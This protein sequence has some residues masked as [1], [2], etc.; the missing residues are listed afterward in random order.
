MLPAEQIVV[1]LVEPQDAVNVGGVI[2]VMLNFGLQQL[3]LVRPAPGA[4]DLARLDD[5]AHRSEGIVQRLTVVHTLAQALADVTHVAGTTARPR[6]RPGDT[7]TPRAAAPDLLHQ[8]DCGKLALVFGPERTGLSNRDLDLC[9][10]VLTIPTAPAYP[11][12]NLAQ[13]ALLVGYE[14]WLAGQTPGAPAPSAGVSQA[15]HH[16]TAGS[17]AHAG[18]APASVGDLEGLFGEMTH[19]L[20][21]VGFLKPGQEAAVMRRLRAVVHRARPTTDEATL[22]RAAAREINKYVERGSS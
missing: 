14:L 3:R 20:R 5:V 21:A 10:V 11:S 22:L 6:T 17:V 2:R 4:V 13:A 9:H 12:L 15:G 19:A 7:S 18:G 8:A 16:P 1:V